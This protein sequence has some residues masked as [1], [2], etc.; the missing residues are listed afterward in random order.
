VSA[1]ISGSLVVRDWKTVVDF[2]PAT[3]QVTGVIPSDHCMARATL[4]IP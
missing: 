1:S 4:V 2:D 3:L